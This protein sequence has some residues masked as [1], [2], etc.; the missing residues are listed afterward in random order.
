MIK[1]S[2]NPQ[3]QIGIVVP[4]YNEARRLL[5]EDFLSLPQNVFLLLV[6]DGST[7]NTLDK[8]KKLETLNK[9]IQVLSLKKNKGKAEAVRM[10][11]KALLKDKSIN[12]FG[13]LDADLSTSIEE[14]LKIAERLE[15]E[16]CFAFGSRIQTINSTIERKYLRFVIG[17][18]VAAIISKVL[19]VRI[20]D[21]QCGCKVFLRAEGEKIFKN[22]FI[23]KWLFDVE[24]FFRLI[25]IKGISNIADC[26]LEYPLEKWI[27]KDGSKVSLL[28]GFRLFFD[29]I[30]I[31]KR[32]K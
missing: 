27:D 25:D 15:G 9:N 23:S 32:Y 13:Y 26:T 17:R 12:I 3:I 5:Q 1:K 29:L 10:G 30:K 8:L 21:T 18:T 2:N 16:V 31:K 14:F 4:C 20:Y 22:Q 7:D 6:N 28:Y 19:N 11:V 24:I